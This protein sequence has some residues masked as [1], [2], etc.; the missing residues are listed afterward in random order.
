MKVKK[1]KANGRSVH[2]S[3]SQIQ[4]NALSRFETASDYLIGPG[5]FAKLSKQVKV[6]LM[7]NRLN[8]VR[9]K[10]KPGITFEPHMLKLYQEM[11][12]TYINEQTFLTLEGSAMPLS[13]FLREGLGLITCADGRFDS[14]NNGE[15]L[16][17][18]VGEVLHFLHKM[19]ILNSD[20]SKMLFSY[21]ATGLSVYSDTGVDNVVWADFKK[22]ESCMVRFDG[23]AREAI[24]L[25]WADIY[26]DACA[27]KAGGKDWFGVWFGA[28]CY[29]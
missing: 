11:F 22:P 3:P 4:S 8:A 18:T 13:L 7:E 6:R 10:F 21:N 15:W 12:S 19:S 27:A 2:H 24:R 9:M 5:H 20:W 28:S 23:I 1:K 26:G 17:K 25:C 14:Y 29:F 16:T